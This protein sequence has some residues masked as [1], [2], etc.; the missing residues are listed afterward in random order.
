MKTLIYQIISTL[1]QD[2]QSIAIEGQNHSITNQQLLE[3][4]REYAHGIFDLE[5]HDSWIGVSTELGWESYA[6]ILGCWITGNG[7][8]PINFNFP[9]SSTQE[10]LSQ[11]NM[12]YCIGC[13]KSIE[14]VLPLKGFSL[15]LVKGDKAYLIFTSGTT[16]VPKGVPITQNN[17]EAFA[18]HYLN[19]NSIKFTSKDKF[20]Q[21]YELTFDV[22]IF[23]FL[24]PF[25]TG[26]TLVLP[27]KRKSK[28]LGLFKTITDFKVTVVSFVPSMIRLT[29]DF[30]PRVQFPN[31]RYSFFSGEALMG[32]W[33]KVWMQSVMNAKVYNCYGPT[34][35]VIV[36]T[37]ELL[38]TLDN[39]YFF[40]GLPLPLGEKFKNIELEIINKEIVFSGK[41][42]FEGYLNQ[43]AITNYESGDLAHYDENGKII[44]DG[45]KDNQ[46]KWNGYRIELEE[47]DRVLTEKSNGWV[48]TI[49]I[50]E[51]P[52]LI[53]FSNQLKGKI[54]SLIDD[55][56]PDYYKPTKIIQLDDLPL[57]SNGK[58]DVDKLKRFSVK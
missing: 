56:F 50:K 53:I 38:N 32:S 15:D 48:K 46:I 5:I 2:P 27:Y 57:N 42:T 25:L 45:R 37:E 39:S 34:E 17:L 18:T 36:C 28:Q 30:L 6:A 12:K 49:F 14:E 40:N 54:A 21:S 51:I 47:M 3:K 23:C 1:E 55:S 9:Q 19:H 20:L 33:A 11:T 13:S 8:V 29:L 10:I 4:A 24:M 31:V 7:Y 41:Q 16:G 44:F 26:G 52:K 43:K 22:S 58:I 35:T